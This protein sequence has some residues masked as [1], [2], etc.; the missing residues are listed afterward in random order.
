MMEGNIGNM[1][2]DLGHA[3]VQSWYIIVVGN[4]Y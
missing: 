2:S 3:I 1:Q 4:K